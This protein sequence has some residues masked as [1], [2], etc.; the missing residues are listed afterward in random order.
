[1]GFLVGDSVCGNI[2]GE[3]DG[4]FIGNCV[5][6]FVGDREGLFVGGRVGFF[7]GESVRLLVGDCVGVFIGDCE[8]LFV[9]GRVGFFVGDCV[10]L[11]V[12][13][14][15]GGNVVGVISPIIP[16]LHQQQASP[17]VPSSEEQQSASV[18]HPFT[19][20]VSYHEQLSPKES[21]Y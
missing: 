5:G 12:G 16:P 8:G 7:V 18:P 17:G 14:F 15:V 11:F 19:V 13:N 6:F 9:G 21:V 1:V 2:I 10:G 4:F 20:F 3:E